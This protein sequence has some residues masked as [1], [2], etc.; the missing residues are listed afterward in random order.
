MREWR[1]GERGTERQREGERER[2]CGREEGGDGIARWRRGGTRG[3]NVATRTC[4]EGGGVG[5]DPKARLSGRGRD[6]HESDG[7]RGPM[8]SRLKQRGTREDGT[9]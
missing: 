8:R 1:I 2:E 3:R 9:A 5:R 6:G 4:G 7:A